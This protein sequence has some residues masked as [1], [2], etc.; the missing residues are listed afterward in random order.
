MKTFK[1]SIDCITVNEN[2]EMLN[3]KSVPI[4]IDG[5]DRSAALLT[6]LDMGQAMSR[7]T[8]RMEDKRAIF[9]RVVGL[10]EV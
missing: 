10:E 3:F 1:A 6:A 4:E 7:S 9:F 5:E 8:N 2:S